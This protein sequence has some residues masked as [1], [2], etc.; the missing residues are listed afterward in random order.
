MLI[1]REENGYLNL[2]DKKE[3]VHFIFF[4]SLIFSLP[5][6]VKRRIKALKK[7]QFS[8]INVEAEFYKEVNELEAKYAD[9]Y[10]A[11]FDKVNQ[12][13]NGIIT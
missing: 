7:L 11:L 10:K 2:T 3:Y 6:E 5:K 4:H 13:Q 12:N 9:K 8:I 1:F